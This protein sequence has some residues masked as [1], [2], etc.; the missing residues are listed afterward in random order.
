M[1]GMIAGLTPA[2]DGSGAAAEERGAL[3]IPAERTGAEL[4]AKFVLEADAVSC[5][6]TG[7]ESADK[8]K[9]ACSSAPDCAVA[10]SEEDCTEALC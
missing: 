10:F 9:A 2:K 7:L 4:A 1:A 3:I 5:G 6:S 8:A